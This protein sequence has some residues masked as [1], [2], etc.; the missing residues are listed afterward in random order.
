ML[1]DKELHDNGVLS[2][3]G[4]SGGVW[5]LNANNSNYSGGFTSGTLSVSTP[6]PF[7]GVQAT[8]SSSSGGLTGTPRQMI[9]NGQVNSVTFGVNA[10]LRA[11]SISVTAAATN[12]S[13]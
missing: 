10:A 13:N 2:A 5:G 4:Y 8:V 3:A 6:V 11:P 12:Y 7:V 1:G 9:P